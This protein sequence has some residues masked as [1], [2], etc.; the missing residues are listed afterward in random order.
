LKFDVSHVAKELDL[1]TATRRNVAEARQ[2]PAWSGLAN[3]A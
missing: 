2:P 3:P 1:M